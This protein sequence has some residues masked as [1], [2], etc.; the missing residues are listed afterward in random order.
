MLTLQ[1][2]Q[3]SIVLKHFWSLVGILQEAN[4]KKGLNMQR[5]LLGAMPVRE[6]EVTS[7]ARNVTRW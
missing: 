2:P 4:A 5:F 1:L 7:K 3:K 6:R